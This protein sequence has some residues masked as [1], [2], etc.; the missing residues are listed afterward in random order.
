M[1]YYT[2]TLESKISRTVH[3]T[4]ATTA[5]AAIAEAIAEQNSFG[6]TETRIVGILERGFDIGDR[7]VVSDHP[8]IDDEPGIVIGFEEEGWVIVEWKQFNYIEEFHW[9]ELGKVIA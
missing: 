8:I 9:T 7:V 1:K 3:H 2:V 5:E 6:N 4:Y